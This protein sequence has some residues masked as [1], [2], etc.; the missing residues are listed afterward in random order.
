MIAAVFPGQGSQTPGMGKDLFDSFAEARIVFESVSSATGIDAAKLC[1][2]TDED[3]LRQTQNAQL[4]LY[5]C[6]V[7]AWLC[8]NTRIGADRITAVAGHSVGEYAALTAAG[9]LSVIS[10]PWSDGEDG[11]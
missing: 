10:S 1:F 7:A 11:R 5:T 4:A 9:V 8:L 3:T 2:E 6:S